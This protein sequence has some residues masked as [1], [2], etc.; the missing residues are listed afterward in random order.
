M[1]RSEEPLNFILLFDSPFL[2]AGQR[3]STSGVLLSPL[4]LSSSTVSLA[5]RV[6][7]GTVLH[8]WHWKRHLKFLNFLQHF[9]RSR[10]TFLAAHWRNERTWD[11]RTTLIYTIWKLRS[12][13]YVKRI[14][15]VNL[16]NVRDDSKRFRRRTTPDGRA[17]SNPFESI[18]E[19]NRQRRNQLRTLR[20]LNFNGPSESC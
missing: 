4:L 14:M 7:P 6:T 12:R 2:R 18:I 11:S 3:N 1:F 10:Y 5:Q 15:F 16:W 19:V 8:L 20:K 9:F 17:R 13:F